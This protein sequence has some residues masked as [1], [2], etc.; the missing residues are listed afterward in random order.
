MTFEDY[1][2]DKTRKDYKYQDGYTKAGAKNA[3]EYQAYKVLKLEKQIEA[4]NADNIKVYEMVCNSD[5]AFRELR[6]LKERN[7]KLEQQ[8]L[9]EA[10]SEFER[11]F[12]RNNHEV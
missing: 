2:K 9:N 7:Q 12:W 8:I 6:T 3:F 1:W 11:D 4:L 10:M 5:E